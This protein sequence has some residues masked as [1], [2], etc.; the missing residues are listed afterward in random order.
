MK[1]IK[2]LL[3]FI[4]PYKWNVFWNTIF[5]I[6]STIFSLLSFT[7]LIP[8][9]KLIM[10]IGDAET[11]NKPTTLGL[12][13]N[14]WVE[15]FN[16]IISQE[17]QSTP[18]GRIRALA[19]VCIGA[20]LASFFKNIFRWLAIYVLAP[21]RNG[22][23]RDLRKSIYHKILQLPISFFSNEKKGDLMT[24]M[25]GDVQEVEWGILNM[26]E[27][28]TKDPIEIL[29]Y[30]AVMIFFSAKLTLL[31]FIVLPISGVIIASI[32]KLLRKWG[33]KGMDKY[34]QMVSLIE[35]TLGG[36]K[37]IKAFNAEKFINKKFDADNETV[38]KLNNKIVRV[39][40]MASPMSEFLGICAVLIILYIGGSMVLD[41]RMDLKREVFI[42]FIV[43][44]S[45]LISPAKSL[46]NSYFNVQKG[47]AALDRINYVLFS[48]NKIQNTQ[49]AIKINTFS[50]S[51]EYKNLNFAYHNFDDNK[52]L[53]NVNVKIQKGKMIALV[54]ASGSGKTTFAD[55]L[56]RFYDVQEGEILIDEINIKNV[57]LNSLRNQI[58]I[59]TQEPILFNDSVFNNIAFGLENVSEQDVI[60]AA[61]VANAHEFIEKLESGY[62]TNIGDRGTK[63][64]GGQRQR[65]TIARAVLKNPPILILDEATSA[66][67]SES[68][69][70]VQEALSKLMK[71]RTS[72]V[73]AH[74]LSTIQS[75][76][77]ILVMQKGMIAERGNHQ[78]LLQIENGHY[79]KL[80]ELQA[81]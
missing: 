37:I 59:V 8:F 10:S 52:V 40:D 9:L 4:L 68:E 30:I 57:E 71:N 34:G 15:Y 38:F 50:H 58:G 73:I 79:K 54:G 2:Q 6:L 28:F 48:E 16:Y 42:T 29:S 70:L 22:V 33:K 45:Q 66:L 1:K 63:L 32:A 23:V 51:I 64:S 19:I 49:N 72:I 11:I 5:N 81:F 14:S 62:Q 18:D 67:D 43:I 76:D 35:E 3:V 61:K 65:L 39:R 74:R 13:V 53:T 31:S 78:Q 26:L 17:I 55:L 25:T 46:S 21:M 24:R 20:A 75:A 47:L 41:G 80:V 36:M 77:E 56:P 60:H 44:F 69:K 7:M 12:S 27:S